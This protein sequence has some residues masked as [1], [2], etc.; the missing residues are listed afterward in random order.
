M[1][2]FRPM[3]RAK[4][5]LPQMECVAILEKATSGTLAVLGDG[6]YPYA[7]PL[8]FAYENGR[9]YFHCARQGHKLDG[10]KREP[11][12]SF[13]VI[14]RDDVVPA[15]YTTRYQSVIVFGRA[16]VLTEESQRRAALRLIADKYAAGEREESRAQM[17]EKALP[18]VC[19]IELTAESVTGKESGALAAQREKGG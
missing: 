8:S 6:G 10:V 2:E 5:R 9:L 17:V 19:L 15:E 3:R 4:Q 14:A 18:N 16:R 7:V 1:D 13:C 11:K 12:V